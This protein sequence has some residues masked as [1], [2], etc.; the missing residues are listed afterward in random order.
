MLD[1]ID[2]NIEQTMEN[3]KKA[4]KHLIKAREYQESG[5][6]RNCMY[7]EAI[8]II[9]LLVIVVIKYTS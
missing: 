2:Y 9:I 4:T 1:R 5:C 8:I 6:G 7:T 3:T